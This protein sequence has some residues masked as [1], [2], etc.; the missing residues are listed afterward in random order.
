MRNLGKMAVAVL[1]AA[2]LATG[3]ARAAS[4]TDYQD[5]WWVATESGWGAAVTQQWD[6]LFVCFFVY[7]PDN[8]PTWF[9]AVATPQAGAAPGHDLFAGDLWVTTGPYY[10]GPWNAGSVERVAGTF[11]FD[12]SG[13][14][15][16]VIDYVVDG[17]AVQ[18]HVTRQTWKTVNI[19][20]SYRG[21]MITEQ[22]SCANPEDNLVDTGAPDWTIVHRADD[23]VTATIDGGDV[24]CVL[25]GSYRQHGHLGQIDGLAGPCNGNGWTA[26]IAVTAHEVTHNSFGMTF[27]ATGTG[28]GCELAI[29]FAGVLK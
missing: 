12:A 24:V 11:S 13:V 29:R 25:D 23:T 10:G 4:T 15:A 9:V 16:A 21:A 6:T 2:V 3:A 20:G 27:R 5:Q 18:K 7:G 19:A 26:Q 14:D 1:A 8:K 22:K 17:V 28:F